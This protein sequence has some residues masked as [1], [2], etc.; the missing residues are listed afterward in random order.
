MKRKTWNDV[1]G[2]KINQHF[3]VYLSTKVSWSNQI[4]IYDTFSKELYDR[5]SIEIPSTI[6]CT[7]ANL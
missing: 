7:E 5:R 1:N 6:N 4:Y 3:I 2:I